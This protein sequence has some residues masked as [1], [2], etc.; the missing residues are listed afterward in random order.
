LFSFSEASEHIVGKQGNIVAA[1]LG[2]L[3]HEDE[4]TAL[5]LRAEIF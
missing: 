5:R 1:R 3:D 2:R 4:G